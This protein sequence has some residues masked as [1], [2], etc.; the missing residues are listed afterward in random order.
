ND[1]KVSFE[2]VA[3]FPPDAQAE[4]VAPITHQASF[5]V[6]VELKVDDWSTCTGLVTNPRTAELRYTIQKRFDVDLEATPASPL[7]S[8]VQQPPRPPAGSSSGGVPA[9]RD[10]LPS[11][12]DPEPDPDAKPKPRPRPGIRQ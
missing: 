1:D 2:F 4:Q 7:P 3:A 11:K 8:P 6:P 5:T 10:P 9:P 12:P